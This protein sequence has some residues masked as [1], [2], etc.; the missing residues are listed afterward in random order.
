MIDSVHFHLYSRKNQSSIS[1]NYIQFNSEVSISYTCVNTYM[2]PDNSELA[3]SYLQ[4][5]YDAL[6][7]PEYNITT[8]TN[9]SITT[10]GS[11]YIQLYSGTTLVFRISTTTGQIFEVYGLGIWYDA[12]LTINQFITLSI[13][14]LYTDTVGRYV[15]DTSTVKLNLAKKFG[16]LK[17]NTSQ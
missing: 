17:L 7:N 10:A 6:N 11:G 1:G 16:N 15:K 4:D 9:K 13:N 14:S 5:L 2:V 8:T 12:D 3:I